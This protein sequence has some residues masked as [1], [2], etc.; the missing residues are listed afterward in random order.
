MPRTAVKPRKNFLFTDEDVPPNPED[1]LETQANVA[2]ESVNP[3]PTEPGVDPTPAPDPIPTPEPILPQPEPDEPEEE[4]GDEDE[5]EEESED[6]RRRKLPDDEEEIPADPPH[7]SLAVT[8]V[9][10]PAILEGEILSGPGSAKVHYE[11]RISIIDA[12]QYPGNVTHAPPWI[13]RNWIGF[14]DYDALRNIEAGPCLRVPSHADPDEVMLARV[15]DYVV[16]QEVRVTDEFA[17]RRTEVWSRQQFEKLFM[18]KTG[19]T[20]PFE[21]VEREKA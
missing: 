3:R 6:Q 10:Q 9:G 1:L 17:D 4:N 15:G 19:P 16:V 14:G 5:D 12:W 21:P 18:P 20:P 7:T 2:P 8:S 13:D 11:G